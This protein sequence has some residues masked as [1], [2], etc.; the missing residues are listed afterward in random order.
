MIT[1]SDPLGR[2]VEP[3]CHLLLHLR[4][5]PQP[6]LDAGEVYRQCCREI[7]QH[8]ARSAELEVSAADAQDALYALVALLDETALQREGALREHWLRRLLQTQFFDENLAGERFFERLAA[9]RGDAKRHAV[10]RVFYLCL[11]LGFRGK[12][13]LRGSELELL[14][15]QES[16][17]HELQRAGA[18]PS[19]L[20][21]SPNGRR[22]Y[23]RLADVRRNQLLLTLAA[24]SSCVAALSYAGMRLALLHQ[25]EQLITRITGLLGV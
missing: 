1:P 2:S 24:I 6:G 10:L 19:Q 25:T 16:I 5:E 23:E 13:H 18:I 4:R 8:K 22:P 11:L 17:R 20:L 15:L 9:L 14:E 3:L 21:L 12:Y 7:E